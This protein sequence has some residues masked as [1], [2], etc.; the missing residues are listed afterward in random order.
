MSQLLPT[1]VLLVN[2]TETVFTFISQMFDGTKIENISK[3]LPYAFVTVSESC[4]LLLINKKCCNSQQLTY[5]QPL[6]TR[7]I[8]ICTNKGIDEI[9]KYSVQAGG[10]VIECKNSSY[11]LF[12]GP[13][14]ITFFVTNGNSNCNPKFSF[15][16]IIISSLSN[17]TSTNVSLNSSLSVSL[18]ASVISMT[19]SK[20]K[21]IPQ[22]PVVA[23]LIP[24]LEAQLLSGKQF[25]P[26]IPNSLEPTPFDTGVFKGHAMLV[27]RT[28][29]IDPKFAS[30]FEGKRYIQPTN[31]SI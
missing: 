25:V 10:R 31:I 5:L 13:E 14:G 23:R 7:H 11:C 8:S 21:K 29:P 22:L 9:Q 12:E 16:D 17:P 27:V 30:F 1:G 4:K 15:H 28:A 19:T 2:N 26:I 6:S 24:T 18:D 20:V 3:P